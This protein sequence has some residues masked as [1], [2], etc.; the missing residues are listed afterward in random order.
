M[1]G[2]L[3]AEDGG[4][5]T[6]D[7]G[8]LLLNMALDVP[9]PVHVPDSPPPIRGRSMPPT[10]PWSR[11]PTPGTRQPLWKLWK[12]RRSFTLIGNGRIATGLE[13]CCE[14]RR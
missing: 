10:P 8:T 7:F 13:A 1:T 14:R 4:A 3:R 11:L 6:L 5:E 9:P 2:E 12:R